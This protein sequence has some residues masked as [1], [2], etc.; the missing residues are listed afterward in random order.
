MDSRAAAH[1]AL[2]GFGPR[3]AAWNIHRRRPP[4]AI[5]VSRHS[6]SVRLAAVSELHDWIARSRSDGLSCGFAKATHE[7]RGP[8][9]RDRMALVELLQ[10]SG[11]SDFL[12]A[13]AVSVIIAPRGGGAGTWTI[14]APR[15]Y[16]VAGKFPHRVI[17]PPVR[18]QGF[19][20]NGLGK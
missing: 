18:R 9:D 12:R 1:C 14:G 15:A 7:H 3:S 13:V 4:P 11:E 6:K 16:G 5:L 10:K 19:R 2:A 8:D 20:D 17:Y